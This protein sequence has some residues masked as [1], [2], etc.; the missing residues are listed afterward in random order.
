MADRPG[1]FR[2]LPRTFYDF[3]VYREVLPGGIQAALGY[4]VRLVAL[5]AALTTILLA[6][7][8]HNRIRTVVVP[9]IENVIKP[10]FAGS[11]ALSWKEGVLTAEGTVP[12][13]TAFEVEER[14]FTVLIDTRDEPDTSPLLSGR[15]L[16]MCFTA[17]RQAQAEDGTIKADSPYGTH[18]DGVSVAAG[19]AYRVIFP[20]PRVEPQA[21]V[22]QF[23]MVAL[24]LLVAAVAGSVIVAG[25]GLALVPD[26]R[27]LGLAGLWTVAAHAMTSGVAAL[28]GVL[29]LLLLADAGRGRVG[30]L[31]WLLW[32]APLAA[33]VVTNWRALR[34]CTTPG[35]AGGK[36]RPARTRRV[37]DDDLLPPDGV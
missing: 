18:Y 13:K 25:I 10:A 7:Y 23:V 35:D 28:V 1:F 12:F 29:G 16:V 26:G 34:A 22:T 15:G 33:A 2:T 5:A 32:S 20:E 21:L 4:L 36:R 11:P 27:Q 8:E 9:T 31:S 3:E 24:M 30:H 6:A 19:E 37:R 17:R 14:P